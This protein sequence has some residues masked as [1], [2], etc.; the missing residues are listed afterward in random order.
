MLVDRGQAVIDVLVV[1]GAPGE[2]P[3]IERALAA[4]GCHLLPC[5]SGASALA[6]ARRAPPDL[7]VLALELPDLS[8]FEVARALRDD[9]LTCHV[10]ILVHSRRGDEKTR[11]ASYASGADCFVARPCPPDELAAAARSLGVRGRSLRDVE[12]GCAVLYA[13][14]DIVDIRCLD[15]RGHMERCARL[16]RAFG[17]V[18]GLPERDRLALERAGYLHDIGKVGVPFDVL[19]KRG[20]L[21]PEE[22]RVVEQHPLIGARIC[23]RLVTLREVVPVI[24]HHHERFDGSGYPF[25][26]RGEAIPLLA[27]VFQVVDVYEALVSE[28]CYKAA[29][30]PARALAI[31]DEE[32]RAGCW[33]PALVERFGRALRAG[34]FGEPPSI[35]EPSW[36]PAPRA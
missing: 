8:G 7:I 12:D 15:A 24:R 29:L 18:L 21:S 19:N 13:L 3:F 27:R 25:G 6:Q 28:R 31:L 17:E 26:L 22:R 35:A 14:A 1:D 9:P 23:E 16:A 30:S 32:S 34:T 20:P 33:D 5:A 11:I 4:E 10:P 36:S 2:L